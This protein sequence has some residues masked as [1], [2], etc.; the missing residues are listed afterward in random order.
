[1]SENKDNRAIII[2]AIVATICVIVVALAVAIFVKNRASRDTAE[3]EI[4]MDIEAEED[5]DEKDSGD[6]QDDQSDEDTEDKEISYTTLVCVPADYMSLRSTAGLGDDVITQ[7]KAGTY[8]K[9]DGKTETV[10]DYEYYHVKVEDSDQEGYVAAKFCVKVDFPY[11]ASEL[12][13]VD[14][15]DDI[16]SY[17]DMIED[18][19]ELTAKYPDIL[20]SEIVG[21]S[22]DGRDIYSLNLGSINATSHV[23]VQASIHGREYMNTQLVMNLVEYYC[24][25]YETGS[26][27]NISYKDLFDKTAFHIIPMANPDGVSISQFGQNALQDPFALEVLYECYQNDLPNLCKEIDTNGDPVWVDHY[28]DENFDLA[29]SVNPQEITF[30]EYLK[31]WKANA[32][33]VD[34]NN[35]FDAGWYELDL[36]SWRSY[37]NFPGYAPASEPETQTLVDFALRYDYDCY[38]S[39]HSRGQLIYYDVQGNSPENRAMSTKLSGLFKEQLKYD[40]V[41]ITN[42]TAVNLGGFGD[43]IQLVLNKP[44]ITIESGKK[45]CPLPQ[46]EFDGIWN[47]HRESW[48]MI[49]E[50]LY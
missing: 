50:Q 25:Y 23:M 49:A 39:Y 5:Q 24:N 14:E 33:G 37:S 32:D 18:I 17:D 31:M 13:I 6:G 8:L 16:Y 42:S 19:N 21:T 46:E 15:S 1:M 3:T 28:K 22:V 45:P 40:P 41:N 11:E 2:L 10:D 12:P 7:L 9:W 35:N 47:R 26:Y 29:S 43:W 48:A 44:S 27:K 36:K 30:D 34:L 20:Y 38:L 4:S